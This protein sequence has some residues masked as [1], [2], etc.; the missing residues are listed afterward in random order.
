MAVCNARCAVCYCAGHGAHMPC[1]ICTATSTRPSARAGSSTCGTCAVNVGPTRAS[2]RSHRALSKR[3]RVQAGG[4]P[5]SIQSTPV[6]TQSTPCEYSEYPRRRV[7]GA[8]GFVTN[9]PQLFSQRGRRAYDVAHEVAHDCILVV[10]AEV[11]ADPRLH[12]ARAKPH[13]ADALDCDCSSN[14]NTKARRRRRRPRLRMRSLLEVS[15][16]W[17]AASRKF[18]FDRDVLFSARQGC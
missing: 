13:C 8:A 17:A 5:V 14:A 15:A 6:S 18:P 2:A 11:L 7:G 4:R 9:L 10:P 16:L 3:R 12:D 1:R